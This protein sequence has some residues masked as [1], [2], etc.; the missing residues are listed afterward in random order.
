MKLKFLL[1][2][3]CLAMLLLGQSVPAFAGEIPADDRFFYA[4]EDQAFGITMAYWQEGIDSSYTTIGDSVY[5]E[6]LGWYA[7]KL[8]KTAGRELISVSEAEDFLDSVGYR[9]EINLPQSWVEYEIVKTIHGAGGSV[10]YDFKRSKALYEARIGID[11]DVEVK[12]ERTD[13]V[14]VVITLHAPEKDKLLYYRVSFSP[15]ENRSSQFPYRVTGMELFTPNPEIDEKLGFSWDLLLEKNRLSNILDH[16]PCVVISTPII[17]AYSCTSLF[18]HN[19]KYVWVSENYGNLCGQYDRFSFDYRYY[20]DGKDRACVSSYDS[21]PVFDESEFENYMITYLDNVDCVD[22]CGVEDDW[23]WLDYSTGW[24]STER[25][26]FERDTL[27]L[28]EI[29]SVNE[30]KDPLPIY[31]FDCT[32]NAPD[33]DFLNGWNGDLR[34]VTAIWED[35]NRLSGDYEYRTETISLPMDWEYLPYV[36]QCG[37]YA[38][39]LDPR[40]NVPYV[41]PGDAMNYTVFFKAKE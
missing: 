16:Y 31:A 32:Q 38:A 6:S 4:V 36:V 28:R 7:A 10:F 35:R 2:L 41:Y 39:F 33:Y 20:P 5:W 19:G 26:V 40:Y 23:I 30:G 34:T 25:Y 13:S 27:I 18:R 1:V 3:I 37:D 17:S 21:A 22:A 14:I 15:N 12:P 11:A 29:Q 8:S 24:G 9:G